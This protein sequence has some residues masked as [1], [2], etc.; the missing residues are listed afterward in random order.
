MIKIRKEQYKALSRYMLAS[1]IKRS[2][3]HLTGIWPEKCK[4]FGD[5]ALCEYIR[6]VIEFAAIDGIDREAD[7]ILYLDLF[8][9]FDLESIHRLDTP[10]A[11]DI[12]EDNKLQSKEKIQELYRRAKTELVKIAKSEAV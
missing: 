4:A 5:L 1:F 11:K 2:A 6:N 3:K 7:V 9:A 8:F 10:W 12:L